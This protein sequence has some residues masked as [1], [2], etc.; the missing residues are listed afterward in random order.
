MATVGRVCLWVGRGCEGSG[1]SFAELSTSPLDRRPRMLN[2]VKT[3]PTSWSTRPVAE[4][5]LYALILA[6]NFLA[7]RSLVDLG[8]REVYV[9]A[10]LF[11]AILLLIP[12]PRRQLRTP[13]IAVVQVSFALLLVHSVVSILW[14]GATVDTYYVIAPIVN[15][16]LTIAAASRLAVGIPVND[17]P[18]ILYNVAIM[19]TLSTLMA[20]LL[21]Q[22]GNAA[23]ATRLG[24]QL[25][26]ASM[27]HVALLLSFGIFLAAIQQRQRV[28]ISTIMAGIATLLIVMT[29]SRAGIVSI[30]LLVALM[31]LRTLRSLYMV[32]AVVVLVAVAVIA[33]RIMPTER[34]FDL[35]DMARSTNYETGFR[36]L[37]ESPNSIIV[38]VGSGAVWPWYA[39]LVSGEVDSLM[40]GDYGLTLRNPH[41][42]F[43]G[44]LVENG[45]VGISLLIA[46]LGTVLYAAGRWYARHPK[47]FYAPICIAIFV[48]VLSFFTEYHLLSNFPLAFIWWLVVFTF[49]RFE[50]GSSE[51]IRPWL[52]VTNQTSRAGS[53]VKSLPMKSHRL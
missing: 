6:L 17:G 29:E 18:R 33:I 16:A 43:V 32:P 36:A 10:L 9:S 34:V 25:A 7:P 14:A 35:T 37:F 39:H 51:D 30:A 23:D 1:T 42:L 22:W 38:G 50:G 27:L 2:L 19:T 4:Y 48:S 31:L 44:V 46:A 40:L 52:R 26:G 24:T 47:T 28:G 11:I 45:I 3:V 15:S 12:T 49:L 20:A 21:G 8:G 13:R 53:K 5:A 41:S